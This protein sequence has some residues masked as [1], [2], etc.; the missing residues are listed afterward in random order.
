M[1]KIR[2]ATQFIAAG[3]VIVAGI[4]L[5]M[6]QF[7]QL[8]DDAAAAR[9]AVETAKLANTAAK[10]GDI[11][12]AVRTYTDALNAAPGR[13]DLRLELTRAQAR[14]VLAALDTL[15]PRT[16]LR[17]QASMEQARDR[18]DTSDEVL[19]ALGRIR[20]AR[21]QLD[22]ARRTFEQV[23]SANPK[24]A[25]GYLFLG[26]L[27]LKAGEL[28]NAQATLKQ[29]IELDSTLTLAKFALGQV[30][31]SRKSFDEAL[32]W[33]ETA[34]REMPRNGQAA[35]AF[36][37]VLAAQQRWPDAMSALERALALEPNLVQ[38]HALLGDAY[39]NTR[40]IESAIGSYKLAWTKAQDLESLRKVGRIYVQLGALEP[41]AGI[42][43]QLTELVPDD[44][45]PLMILGLVSN[46]TGQREVAA[47][48]WKRCVELS[49]AKPEWAKV[50]EKCTE[51]AAAPPKGPAKR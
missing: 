42:F 21:G 2:Q 47:G 46:A 8:Q 44:P 38:V 10:A 6:N 51:L 48:Q 13:D 28:D 32:P 12:L 9:R 18:G 11:D 29:A 30:L 20:T 1:Q 25:Q 22:A 36:G 33:L 31:L 37:R 14:Q 23:I 50:G 4:P 16:T 24:S 27:Q 45:E 7:R 43:A 39:L 41:A 26:D 17:L 3:V 49:A 15:D 5:A 34:A 35:L 40:R 19:L